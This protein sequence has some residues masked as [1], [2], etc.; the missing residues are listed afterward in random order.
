MQS[1]T[2]FGDQSL[3]HSTK[4]FKRKSFWQFSDSKEHILLYWNMILAKVHQLFSLHIGYNHG[5][6]KWSYA[7]QRFETITLQNPGQ[8]ISRVD[9]IAYRYNNV[10]FLVKKIF[11]FALG[12]LST[13]QTIVAR[14]TVKFDDKRWLFENIV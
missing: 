6:L 4:R 10:F 3:L 14:K 1:R 11:T 13:I 8:F 5:H 9:E 7:A 2:N 12:L